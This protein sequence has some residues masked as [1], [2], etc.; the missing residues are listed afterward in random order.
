MIWLNVWEFILYYM[1]MYIFLI[2][3]RV[4]WLVGV[5]LIDR[6]TIKWFALLPSDCKLM[7]IEQ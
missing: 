2:R 1:Y 3:N 5:R 6:L 7:Y 4:T